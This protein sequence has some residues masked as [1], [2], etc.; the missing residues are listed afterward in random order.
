MKQRLRGKTKD[1]FITNMRVEREKVV[2]LIKSEGVRLKERFRGILLSKW[3]IMHP[4]EPDPQKAGFTI[5][6]MKVNGAVQ[7][8][9]LVR[10]LPDGEFDIDFESTMH[11]VMKEMQDEGYEV[12]LQGAQVKA[13]ARFYECAFCLTRFYSSLLTMRPLKYFK[14]VTCQHTMACFQYTTKSCPRVP[15][16]LLV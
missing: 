4:E 11:T 7:D 5:K 2:Q 12:G 8:V 13:M 15:G 6:K 3:I 16:G 14:H 9:V 1:G 10:M